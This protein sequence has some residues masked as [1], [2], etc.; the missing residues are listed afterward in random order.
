MAAISPRTRRSA[1]F[2]KRDFTEVLQRIAWRL[3]IKP[4]NH[5]LGR[6]R[7]QRDGNQDQQGVFQDGRHDAE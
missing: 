7:T 2:R 1:H 5:A 3:G 4:T 6:S